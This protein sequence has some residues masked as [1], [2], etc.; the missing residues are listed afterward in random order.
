MTEI[1]RSDEKVDVSTRSSD[2]QVL[3]YR[4]IGDGRLILG[5]S[6][7]NEIVYRWREYDG[8]QTDKIKA[9]VDVITKE[10]WLHVERTTMR[11]EITAGYREEDDTW[12]YETIDEKTYQRPA[13]AMRRL[14]EELGVD[15]DGMTFS[16]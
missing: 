16:H 5:D 6:N 7:E 2:E 4:W 14:Y 15:T 9:D 1:R 13:W 10:V 12:A 11:V 8:P 3:A